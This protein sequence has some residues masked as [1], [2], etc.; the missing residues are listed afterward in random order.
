MK[1]LILLFASVTMILGACSP[2]NYYSYK[3]EK[4]DFSKYQTFAWLPSKETKV[5]GVFDNNI[6][7]E[8]IVEAASQ[9]LNEKG[10]RLDSQ[11]PDLLIKYTAVV[12]DKTRTTSN[13]VYYRSPS[14]YVPRVAYSGGRRYFYYQYVNPFPVYVGSEMRKENFEEGSVMIDLIDRETSKVVWRGWGKGQINNPEKAISDI[15]KVIEKIFGK[16]PAS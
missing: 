1:K 3:S 12:N 8:S 2:Y 6:A 13:P 7:E 9:A 14:Y 10:F 11:Q 16:F 15:P 4:A 5:N